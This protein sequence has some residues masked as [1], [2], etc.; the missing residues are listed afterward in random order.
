MRGS[1]SCWGSEARRTTAKRKGRRQGSQACCISRYGSWYRPKRTESGV[2]AA[3]E[4]EKALSLSLY[5][6]LPGRP[7]LEL[8]FATRPRK[9]KPRRDVQ[10]SKPS[11]QYQFLS[12]LS[13]LLMK[14]LRANV[15]KPRIKQLEKENISPSSIFMMLRSG[16][17]ELKTLRRSRCQGRPAT[18]NSAVTRSRETGKNRCY[19]G[20][21]DRL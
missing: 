1:A 12:L 2:R 13:Y 19:V 16:R 3:A 5:L 18:T 8:N 6:L 21:T 10:R 11:T 4:A 7:N 15:Q 14:L 20:R 17:W 9:Q